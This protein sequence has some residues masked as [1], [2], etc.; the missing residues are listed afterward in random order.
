[1]FWKVNQI[2]ERQFLDTADTFDIVLFKNSTE[3]EESTCFNHAALILKY[4]RLPDEV[5]VIQ[6]N[7]EKG[8]TIKPWSEVRALVGDKISKIALKCL[9]WDRTDS[10]R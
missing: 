4:D 9:S 1:M 6:P 5:F 3:K 10:N 8:V 2:S 7:L